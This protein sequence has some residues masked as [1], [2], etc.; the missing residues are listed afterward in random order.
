MRSGDPRAAGLVETMNPGRID[1]KAD[2]LART[3]G[4]APAQDGDDFRPGMVDDQM[5]LRAF[6]LDEANRRCQR[7]GL[8]SVAIGRFS[9]RM[10]RIAFPSWRVFVA[11]PNPP[12]ALKTPPATLAKFVPRHFTGPRRKPLSYQDAISA[13]RISAA[14]F[15]DL[16][17]T[18]KNAS[19]PL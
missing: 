18:I 13:R 5:L 19:I 10:P 17:L 9:G 1:R 14:P 6:G 16:D 11:I 7:P 2:M 12:S 8:P 3:I 15:A 4:F